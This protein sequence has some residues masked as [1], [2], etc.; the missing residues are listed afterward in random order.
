[1]LEELRESGPLARLVQTGVRGGGRTSASNGQIQCGQ[2]C[3]LSGNDSL[4]SLV[5]NQTSSR[6]LNN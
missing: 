4:C 6:S 2:S 3:V 1:M 5:A